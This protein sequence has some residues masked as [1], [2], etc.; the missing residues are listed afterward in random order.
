MFVP[1]H[2]QPHFYKPHPVA[3]SL[4]DRVELELDHLQ[5]EGVIAPVQ[6]S[7]RA[8]PIVPVVKADGSILI[9]GDYSGIVNSVSKLDSYPLPEWR[10]FSQQCMEVNIS[11]SLIYLMLANSYSY[12]M[13]QESTLQLTQARDCLNTGVYPSVSPPLQLYFR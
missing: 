13:S 10:T 1:P 12:R 8:A 4:K 9:C 11:P 7:D 3:Y 2:T 5:K 6:F